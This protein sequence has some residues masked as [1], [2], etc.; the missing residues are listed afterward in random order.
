MR[1][2]CYISKLAAV[3]VMLLIAIPASADK[4]WRD[5]GN[6]KAN[7]AEACVAPLP[8]IRRNHMAMLKHQRDI[9]VHKGVRYT[10]NALHG[11]IDCHANKDESGEH[12][13]VDAP[14]QFCAG[15]HEYVSVKLDCFSCHATVPK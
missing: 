3:F 5:N 7:S 11:C 9:T 12:I 10:D 14:G 4:Y 13:A 1:N 8:E 6:A 2:S 15:C